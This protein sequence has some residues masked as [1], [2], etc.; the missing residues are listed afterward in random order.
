MATESIVLPHVNTFD[1]GVGI[2][3]LSGTARNL[4]VEPTPSPPMLAPGTRQSFAI[5]RI[6]ST[7]DLQESLGI[8]IEA[9]YGC[10]SF[11]A[12]V[13]AR[14][15]FAQESKVHESSLFMTVTATVHF[16]DLSI[17][18]PQLTGPASDV[19][20]NQVFKSRY[21]DMFC[22]AM[23]R[24]GLF[25][26]LLR[27]E[28][29]K[30]SQV[31]DLAAELKG[32]YGLFSASAKVDF[33]KSM[34]KFDASSYCSLHTEGGP[35]IEIKDPTDPM[36]LLEGANTWKNA[37]YTDPDKYAVPY[38]WTMSATTIAE[39]PLP[40][41][42]AQI[43]H[44]QDVLQF[45]A[46]ER[47]TLLDQLNQLTWTYQNRGRFD[48]SESA[49]A[50]AFQASARQ[51]Q[52]DLDMVAS[53]AS[54]A[55]S[56]PTDAVFPASYAEQNGGV[57]PSATVPDP[58]PREK[59]GQEVPK[60]TARWEVTEL[61]EPGSAAMT[62][63]VAAFSRHPRTTEV[64]WVAADTPG[65]HAAHWAEGAPWG[66]YTMEAIYEGDAASRTACP[67]ASA[68][69]GV[70]NFCYPTVSKKTQINWWLSDERAAWYRG[71][72]LLDHDRFAAPDARLG[73][74]RGPSAGF[75]L[76][77]IGTDGSIQ[78]T[79]DLTS[80]PTQN[81]TIYGSGTASVTGG[82]TAVTRQPGQY[83]I[84]WVSPSGAV[85]LATGPA[86]VDWSPA[87]EVAPAGSASPNSVIAAVVG[88]VGLRLFWIGADGS[89]QSAV[90][91]GGGQWTRSQVAEPGWASPNADPA[92]VNREASNVQVVW[93]G[94]DGS[95][96]SAVLVNEG[97]EHSV[98]APAGAA[99]TESGLAAVARTPTDPELWWVGQNG[100]VKWARL[101]KRAAPGLPGANSDEVVPRKPERVIAEPTKYERTGRVDALF[102]PRQSYVVQTRFDQL[103]DPAVASEARRVRGPIIDEVIAGRL[104]LPARFPAEGLQ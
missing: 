92:A 100:S 33:R 28:T 49:P 35:S 21:G 18:N 53:C 44:C 50:E 16:A 7:R 66:R 6:V 29:K 88:A 9:S 77:F 96:E 64:M 46:R 101:V 65:L 78:C 27:I 55:M 94:P 97:W 8:D 12:G 76:F 41:D 4:V 45:C 40:P 58:F 51:T 43:Q 69:F 61:A 5:S 30:S 99:S 103:Y 17:D 83:D 59:P 32:S 73:G 93:V 10:A 62:A 2:E 37:M 14:F 31:D 54:F 85:S 87:R 74:A 90:Q 67:T 82:I 104:E 95:V 63:G 70:F 52:T 36:E 38:E 72:H 26:G 84:A 39:G 1:F 3:R 20:D 80:S 56:S 102:D 42:A 91:A 24:G 34:E 81:F 47:T 57:Y 75:A 98:I 23:K 89:V 25:V 22:R 86:G 19:A 15:K 79:D 13:S 60:A 48:W 68:G 11:G 71:L